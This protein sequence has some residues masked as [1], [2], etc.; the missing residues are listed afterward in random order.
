VRRVFY[1]CDVPGCGAVTEGLT[2][3]WWTLEVS[4]VVLL[5]GSQSGTVDAD[6]YRHACSAAHAELVW[7]AIKRDNE[8]ARLVGERSQAEIRAHY[9]EP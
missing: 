1:H 6:R 4:T 9:E 5:A 8:D 7:Q 3:G 2:L